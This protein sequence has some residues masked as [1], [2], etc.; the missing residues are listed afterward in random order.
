MEFDIQDHL[1]A[2][3]RSVSSLEYGGRPARAVTPSQE[4]RGR[5]SGIYGTP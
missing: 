2:F 5:R 1:A 4:L 3:E